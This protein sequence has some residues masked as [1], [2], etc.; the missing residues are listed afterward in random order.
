MGVPKR[1]KSKMKVR[2]QRAANRYRGVQATN[3]TVCGA[4]ARPHRVCPSCG[5]YKGRQ[6]IT[7]ES[8]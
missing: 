1:K 3:C 6:V 2:Q 7:V 8:K 5:N 4:P